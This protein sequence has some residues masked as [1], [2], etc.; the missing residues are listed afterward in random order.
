MIHVLG[1]GNIGCLFAVTLAQRYDVELLLRSNSYKTYMEQAYGTIRI[2]VPRPGGQLLEKAIPARNTSAAGDYKIEKLVVAAKS[3]DVVSAMNSVKEHI[4]K[5][6]Q[7][8]VVHNGM[9]VLEWI[10][11]QFEGEQ[12]EHLA[13]AVTDCG[14][15][16][17]PAPYEF[18][19]TGG[20]E[21]T[22]STPGEKFE[23]IHEWVDMRG[24]METNYNAWDLFTYRQKRKLVI[25]ATVNPITALVGCRNGELLQLDRYL[26]IIKRVVRED[27]TILGFDFDELLDQVVTSL[28]RTLTTRTSMLG[29]TSAGRVTEIDSIN[30]YIMREAKQKGI[31]SPFNE[32]LYDLV[33]MR[34]QYVRMTMQ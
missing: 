18:N 20:G 9:G 24:M 21:C 11:E 34:S 19:Y 5:D 33:H 28:H 25:N 26:D 6:T 27:C 16:K 1:C 31:P 15:S 22:V 12:P 2:N 14:V 17:E 4:T 8:I 29:D 3:H 30:G 7:V 23:L 10:K 32:M 13:F